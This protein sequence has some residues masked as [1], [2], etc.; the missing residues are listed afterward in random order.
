MK[1]NMRSDWKSVAVLL[2]LWFTLVSAQKG[3]LTVGFNWEIFTE[4]DLL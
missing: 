3:A 1:T 4:V 2:F